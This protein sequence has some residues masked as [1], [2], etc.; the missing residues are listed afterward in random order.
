[1]SAAAG[2]GSSPPIALGAP[3]FRVAGGG[4]EQSL[5][6]D[7]EGSDRVLSG[8]ACQPRRQPVRRRELGVGMALRIE[9]DDVVAIDQRGVAFDRNV[10]W[11]L[12]LEAE[13]SAAVRQ[14]IGG[15]RRG[16]VK[17]G[18]HTAANILVPAAG[19]GL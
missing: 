3:L 1:M 13:P 7:L 4:M 11:P 9:F 8:F 19:A 2:G 18:A 6:V 5:A 17:R 14:R 16:G 10:E 15:H 12:V